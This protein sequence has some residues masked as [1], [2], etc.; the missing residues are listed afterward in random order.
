MRERKA[1]LLGKEAALKAALL[2]SN[3][4][5]TKL[6]SVFLPGRMSMQH[7]DT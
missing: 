5:S 7:A 1:N 2:A 6:G 3:V 4:Y